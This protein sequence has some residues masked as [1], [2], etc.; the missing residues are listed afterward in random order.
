MI[1]PHCHQ[2]VS[3][4]KAGRMIDH[5]LSRKHHKATYYQRY[6]C[7][8]CFRYIKGEILVETPKA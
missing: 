1:C 2:E 6:Q 5:A 3:P 7:T 8:G 4:K